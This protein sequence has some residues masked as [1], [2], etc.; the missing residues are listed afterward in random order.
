[1]AV[2]VMIDGGIATVTLN[3][4]D[5]LNA[6]NTQ[7]LKDAVAILASLKENRSVRAVI[8]T[9]AGERAFAAGADIKEMVGLD[10]DGAM[11]FGRLGHAVTR[12]VETL[13]QPVI[14]AVNGFA[15]GG[16]CEL[17]LAADVRLASENAVFGQPEV[18]LGI[19]PGWGGT[20]R[21]VRAVGP[22]M[23]AEMIL[24][25]RRVKADEAV[26]IGLVN[27]VYSLADLMPKAREMAQMIAKNSPLAVR[28]SKRLMQLAFNGQVAS[29]LDTELHAFADSF[30]T[31]D[32]VEGMSA[33]VEKRSPNYADE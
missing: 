17:A 4:P 20:Q 25:G 14:A 32:Q 11:N 7:Q 23:A 12:G 27:A 10:R 3:R 16:G 15:M 9:G 26:R 22:G 30:G 2:D 19:P 5:A 31:A 28:A 33:F 18:S 8:L 1:M 29:G 24:T 6:F 21:L 13:P